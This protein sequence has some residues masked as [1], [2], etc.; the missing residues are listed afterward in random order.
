[1]HRGPELKGLLP[2]VLTRL[3]A[4]ALKALELCQDLGR[5]GFQTRH[6]GEAFAHIGGHRQAQNPR[7]PRVGRHHPALWVQHQDPGGQV[8]QDGLQ[9]GPRQAH[10][11]HAALDCASRFKKLLGHLRK[12][13][14]EPLQIVLSGEDR[15]G[16][17]VSRG[18][19]SHP[20]D[21][22]QQGSG[23]L[24]AQENGQEHCAKH[25]Q[26]QTERQGAD[27][28][29]PEP[30]P[31]QGSLLVLRVGRLKCQGVCHQGGR[32]FAADLQHFRVQH[33]VQA[34][35]HRVDQG[36]DLD[37]RLHFGMQ[38]RILQDLD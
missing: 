1:M 9:I 27:V 14:R 32:E 28:H 16:V 19:L 31:G 21:Q 13:T 33:R 24:V 4:V 2:I 7:R 15:F 12:G 3:Q 22:Q 29:A 23:Q 18:H 25:R 5:K 30:V 20:G 34:H 36:E 38:V 37:L 6:L 8:V 35:T 11:A 26:K 10:L 17:Q